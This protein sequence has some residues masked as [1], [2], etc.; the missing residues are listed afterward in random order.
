[1]INRA[2]YPFLFLAAVVLSSGCHT[3]TQPSANF[4]PVAS[5]QELMQDVVDP[6]AD[7]VWNAVE[8]IVT[9]DGETVQQPR[10]E[11]EW[12]QVRRSAVVLLESA[13]LLVIP[14]RRVGLRPFP[15]EATGALDSAQIQELINAQRP[16]FD[17][18]AAALRES[19]VAALAA[20]DARDPTRLVGAGGGIDQVCEGCHLKFWYPNQVIPSLPSSGAPGR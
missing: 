17:A 1:M 7:G 3:K 8:T 2:R 5:L 14:G 13:N 9:R 16:V 18:F 12:L 20:I 4:K 10:S 15:A 11:T 19:A 6:S